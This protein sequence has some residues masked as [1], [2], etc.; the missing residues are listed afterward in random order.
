M[1]AKLLESLKGGVADDA[2]NTCIWEVGA[3]G[4]V[5]LGNIINLR[6]AWIKTWSLEKQNKR[7]L[8][9]WHGGKLRCLLSEDSSW[10]LGTYTIGRRELTTV[11][12]P[13]FHQQATAM[14][15]R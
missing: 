1:E 11:S 15:P 13:G 8:A 10:M 4:R 7:G 14:S 9:K 2:C 5:G 6:L 3:T 12:S